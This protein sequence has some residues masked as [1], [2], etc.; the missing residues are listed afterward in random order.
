MEEESDSD[1]SDDDLDEY[2]NVVDGLA[3]R[4]HR[5]Q[6]EGKTYEPTPQEIDYINLVEPDVDG[7]VLAS[8]KKWKTKNIEAIIDCAATKPDRQP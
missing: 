1:L 4:L 3:L 5:A 7:D 2:Q 8:F 6:Q